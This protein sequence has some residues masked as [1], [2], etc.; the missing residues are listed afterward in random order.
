MAEVSTICNPLISTIHIF[1]P[2]PLSTSRCNLLQNGLIR[3]VR[4]RGHGLLGLPIGVLTR[5][6]LNTG[7]AV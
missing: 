3:M 4:L 7:F 2:L 1:T 6:V 5:V